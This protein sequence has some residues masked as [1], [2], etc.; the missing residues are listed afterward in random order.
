VTREA[1]AE[2][3]PYLSPDDVRRAVNSIANHYL[4][5]TLSGDLSITPAGREY[6]AEKGLPD[7]TL[8]D[9]R[10][11]GRAAVVAMVLGRA[12]A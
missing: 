10:D 2:A 7:T 5:R 8:P 4:H 11:A 12:E 9:G 3:L 6:L 1:V